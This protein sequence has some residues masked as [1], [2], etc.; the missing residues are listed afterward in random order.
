MRYALTEIFD[1]I[2]G[3]GFHAGLPMTFVRFAGCSIGYRD[4]PWCDT[5]FD[6]RVTLDETEIVARCMEKAVCLTGG[7]PLDR[8]LGPVIAAAKAAGK[9]LHLETSGTRP[10]PDGLGRADWIAVSP[11]RGVR[12]KAL[13]R[14][15]EVKF[16]IGEGQPFTLA[17]YER[18]ARLCSGHIFVQPINGETEIAWPRV[19]QCVAIARAHPGWRVSLQQHK[20]LGVP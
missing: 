7:E 13:T 18:M 4:C 19:E 14:A 3:E 5:R 17:E 1:S 15:D 12:E 20:L 9:R 2:Q 10:I 6:A 11:K 8:D 16:L